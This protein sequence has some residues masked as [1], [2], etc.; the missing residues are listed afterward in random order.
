MVAL[1]AMHTTIVT[2]DSTKAVIIHTSRDCMLYCRQSLWPL[3]L[4]SGNVK[5]IAEVTKPFL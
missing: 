1:R 3:D 5:R 2:T 4:K